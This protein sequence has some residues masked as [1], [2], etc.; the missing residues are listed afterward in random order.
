MATHELTLAL[1][2]ESLVAM[3]VGAYAE[4]ARRDLSRAVGQADEA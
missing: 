1:A 4:R 3:D 2:H